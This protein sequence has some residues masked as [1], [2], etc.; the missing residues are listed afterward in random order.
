LGV[1]KVLRWRQAVQ[2]GRRIPVG[3]IE[4]LLVSD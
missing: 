1:G 3:E 2:A 4:R